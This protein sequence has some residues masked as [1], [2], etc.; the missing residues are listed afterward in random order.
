MT[1]VYTAA[2][3]GFAQFDW[4]TA[5]NRANLRV[6]SVDFQ[7]AVRIFESATLERW[8]DREDYGEDRWLAV[9]IVDGIELTVVYTD[10]ET[11]RGQVRRIIS[12]RRA[13]KNEREAYYNAQ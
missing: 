7:D 8:D 4:D 11:D 12:A 6:H 2:K 3:F 5:K 9:G 10:V 1:I 13:T